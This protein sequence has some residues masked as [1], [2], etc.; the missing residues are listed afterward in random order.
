MRDPFRL[1]LAFFASGAAAL[2]FEVL[3]F[4]ALGRVLGNTVWAAALVLTAFMLGIALGGLLAARWAQRIRN[5]ARAFAV[6]EL[7]GGARRQRAGVGVAVA[8]APLGRWLSPLADQ[9]GPERERA[10][11]ACA[12]GLLLPCIAM[13][14]TLPMGVR[15]L[16]R[17]ETTRALG[18][19]YAAN[20]FGACLAPMVAEHYL[21]EALG[22]RGTALSAAALNVLAAAL[23]PG[24][25]RLTPAPR[26]RRQA[27]P[28]RDVRLLIAAAAT[29]AIALALEVV[30]FRLLLLYAP[31]T[32]ATFALLLMLMLAGIALGGL[33]APALSRLGF[34]M[35]AAASSRGRGGRLLTSPRERGPAR[36]CGRPSFSW[37]RRRS[38]R[39]A[40][41]PCSARSFARAA[42]IRSRPSAA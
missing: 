10:P 8:E 35:L 41:S 9:T 37:R 27:G 24:C 20:T 11:G 17:T 32:D 6:A 36:C 40:F 18:M 1:S 5:P 21:I 3:W 28:A 15:L 23:G 42:R 25:R 13:G 34:P 26:R 31:A 19:L 22:L 39:A 38:C 4:R 30:W 33:C 29:G 14:M 2:L 12:G 16:A 7:G